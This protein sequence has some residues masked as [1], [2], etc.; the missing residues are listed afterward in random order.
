[1]KIIDNNK[2]ELSEFAEK[3]KEGELIVIP[4]ET[5]YG[6][7]ANALNPIAVEKIF[8]VKGRPQ[9]NPL[10]IHTFSKDE[11]YKYTKNQPK[12]VSLLID[13]F[14]PGP[15]TL[16]LEK[17]ELIPEIIT[18]GLDSV[19][20]RI[21]NND[22]T[23]ELLKLTGFPLAAPSANKSG[24]PSPTSV[25]HIIDDYGKNNDIYGIIDNGDCRVGIESTILKC[26]YNQAIIL[27]P[28]NITKEEIEEIIDI[29]IID[30]V[31]TKALAPGMK[32]KHYSP[33]IPVKL[34]DSKVNNNSET[35]NLSF[36]AEI[37]DTYSLNEQN[38]YSVFRDAEKK[39]KQINIIKTESL[40]QSKG[41]LNRILKAI[42]S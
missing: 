21:P 5:V 6:L 4:T 42:E 8:K 16:V 22:K 14:M 26:E 39:Y 3:L 18:A 10:I 29:K 33:T 31:G 38:L 1:M 24:R 7:A 40:L 12:Y 34:S 13:R 25:N 37:E 35:L 11:V 2:E 19:A 17:S 9:D 27:R 23:L 20:I 15:L 36:N 41:L 30:Y 32:Y 28:G